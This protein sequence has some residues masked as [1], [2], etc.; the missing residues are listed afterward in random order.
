MKGEIPI[1]PLP[2][3]RYNRLLW[4]LWWIFWAALLLAILGFYPIV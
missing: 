3:Y 4:V 2:D 1:R